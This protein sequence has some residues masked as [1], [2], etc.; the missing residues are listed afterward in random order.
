VYLHASHLDSRLNY[1]D[2]I[3]K[4]FSLFVS[5]DLSWSRWAQPLYMVCGIFLPFCFL[6]SFLIEMGSTSVHGLWDLSPFRDVMKLVDDSIFWCWYDFL[7]SSWARG[8]SFVDAFDV[9]WLAHMYAIWFY[10]HARLLPDWCSTTFF[11]FLRSSKVHAI[12]NFW[13]SFL[14]H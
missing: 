10:V 5:H 11:M 14:P 7:H 3:L 13:C 4:S 2:R 8:H 12:F 6:W 9:P 1:Y